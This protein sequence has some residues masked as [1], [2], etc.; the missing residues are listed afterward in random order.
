MMKACTLL[1]LLGL[2]AAQQ[3]QQGGD[4]CSAEVSACQS[5]TATS[6][7]SC[8]TCAA[9]LLAAGGGPPDEAE[10]SVNAACG[11]LTACMQQATVQDQ[12]C[13]AEIGACLGSAECAAIMQPAD[14]GDPDTN[15]CLANAE[16][17]ATV[18]C[19]TAQGDQGGGQTAGGGGLMVVAMLVGFDLGMSCP[20]VADACTINPT[21]CV[22]CDASA[23]PAG[24]DGQVPTGCTLRDD[25]ATVAM[26]DGTGEAYLTGKCGFFVAEA[27]CTAPTQATDD[28]GQPT[29][30]PSMCVWAGGACAP[31]QAA[32]S[33]M[34]LVF[35]MA[36]GS[37]SVCDPSTDA[38]CGCTLADLAAST[39]A[40]QSGENPMS[41]ALPAD[42]TCMSCMMGVGQGIDDSASDADLQPEQARQRCMPA[43]FGGSGE[44]DPAA[45]LEFTNAICAVPTDE[46]S[47]TSMSGGDQGGGGDN[48]AEAC[49]AEYAACA[50]SDACAA[51][52]QGGG[53][54]G[55]D[56]DACNADAQCGPLMACMQ[57]AT[58]QDQPCGAEIGVCLGSAEC[59]AILQ[60]AGGGDPDTNACLANAE[61][62]A[63]VQCQTAQGDQGGGGGDQQG[64]GGDDPC[65]AEMGVCQ[66]S[67][68]CAAILQAAGGGAPDQAQ[69]SADA[70]CGPLMGRR[71]V[72]GG[73]GG[74]GGGGDGGGPPMCEWAGDPDSATPSLEG[75]CAISTNM[76]QMLGAMV[77]WSQAPQDSMCTE[78]D[79]FLLFNNRDSLGGNDVT[80]AAFFQISAGCGGC[81]MRNG[82]DSSDPEQVEGGS[83]AE[84]M[85]TAGEIAVTCPREVAACQASDACAAEMA[86][87]LSDPDFDPTR[88]TQTNQ[89]E[90]LVFCVGREEMRADPN[91]IGVCIPRPPA[92][93]PPPPVVVEVTVVTYSATEA[94][95]A[96]TEL[97][98]AFEA[99]PPP[100]PGTPPPPPAP[101]VEIAATVG[102]AIELS[103]IAEGSQERTDFEADFKTSMAASIGGGAAVTADKVIVDA[104]T[105]GRRRLLDTRRM[106][107]GAV[108]VDFHIVA[109][110]SVATQAASLV[111]AVDTSTISV[112]GATAS[113]ISAP[114]VT[115]PPDTDCVGAW[116]A[117]GADCN[118]KVYRVTTVAS[119]DGAACAAAHYDSASCSGGDGDCPAVNCAGA[120]SD[121][122]ADC[123]AKT[124][125]VTTAADGG[126]ACAAADGATAACAAG[127]GACPPAP[128][129]AAS[130]PAPSPSHAAMDVSLAMALL[131]SVVAQALA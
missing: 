67:A 18:Q 76:G 39:A 37:M 125:T 15:A 52:L 7:D 13:G 73:G 62:A 66:G 68:T 88:Q 55:P 77:A 105:N 130:P 74:F 114:V 42:S 8:P 102:F 36:T 117:C 106:Q 21:V 119:G 104:I 5:S 54:G 1:L 69:C 16:C 110:A 51:I 123:A 113:A 89:M 46:G 47:C 24:D 43:G 14:G 3:D 103:S 29:E 59:A 32:L 30:E 97:V 118:D 87:T 19:Q 86:A 34:G 81:M 101:V 22:D 108:D 116:D 53:D 49:P 91:G 63:T 80:R 111:A 60:P 78:A 57:Q 93:P 128:A 131:A 124:Y 84:T 112:A 27:T 20:M 50:Q 107:T 75:T 92:P 82:N 129:P 95:T 90:D 44:P 61:C 98:A 38:D 31:T 94:A 6:C 2:A 9:I 17:A 96:A 12:P 58:V 71:N 70:A 115:A 83:D 25:Y 35:G 33:Q 126:S 79:L 72:A 99:P 121:C 4:P 41:A 127:D 56:P 11:A 45:M 48:P 85:P 26:L 100:P 28:A 65:A 23:C 64:G 122:G 40:E 10:C 109:P 120:W